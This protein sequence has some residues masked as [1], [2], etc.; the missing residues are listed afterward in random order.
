MSQN[1]SVSFIVQPGGKLSG[2]L[3]VPG[4]KSISHRSI[5]FGSISEGTT[6]IEGFLQGEDSLATLNAFKAMG[7]IIDGPDEQGKVTIHGVGMNGL[8]KPEVPLD[9]GNSGTSMRLLTG[10][11]SAQSFE[12]TLIGD[13]SLSGRPMQRVTDPVKLMG[14]HLLTTEKGTAPIIIKIVDHLTSI[15]YVLPMASAQVKSCILL[16]GLYAQGETCVTEPAPT[17]DHTE[18]M[19]RGFGYDLD[20]FFVSYNANHIEFFLFINRVKHDMSVAA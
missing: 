1:K 11:L 14:A 13:A 5:I 4:D 17:R 20:I 6:N 18:R 7:V 12:L 3:R 19:L 2:K 9:L 8:Q 15:N 16:A 10:L